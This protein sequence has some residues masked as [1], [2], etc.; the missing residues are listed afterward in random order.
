MT[1]SSFTLPVHILLMDTLGSALFALGLYGLIA[2]A[3]LPGMEFLGLVDGAWYY[4]VCGLVMWT[5]M[6]THILKTVRSVNKR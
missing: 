1:K 5:P 3:E 6:V 2:K 4:I